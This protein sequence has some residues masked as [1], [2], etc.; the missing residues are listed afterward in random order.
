MQVSGRIIILSAF[1]IAVALAGGA[2]WYHY[3]GSQRAAEFWGGPAARQLVK[4]PRLELLELGELAEAG[5]AKRTVA[6]RAV[7]AEHDLSDQPG[8]VHLRFIFTQDAHF[9]WAGR[10]RVP[11]DAELDW[12]YAL[13]FVEGEQELIVLLRRD[14]E[15][16]GKLEGEHIDVLPS[17]RIAAPVMQ[18]LSRDIGVLNADAAAR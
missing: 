15:Q 4:S 14:F 9:E 13:R 8:L 18:Y 1:A 17:P 7:L 16:I 3:Q 5:E 6:G 10:K 12:A 11:L 2:W